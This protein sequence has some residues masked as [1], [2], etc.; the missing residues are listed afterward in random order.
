MH[1]TREV[2]T[3]ENEVF[4]F[5]FSCKMNKIQCK[6]RKEKNS[7]TNMPSLGLVIDF[8]FFYVCDD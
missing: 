2:E 7:H 5:N 1:Q 8:I 4:S 6:K 3:V